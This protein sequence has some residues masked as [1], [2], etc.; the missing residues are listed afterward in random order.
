[1]S[2]TIVFDFDGTLALGN[3][4]VRAF[5][6]AIEDRIGDAGFVARA[7]AAVAG[8]E[9]GDNSFRDGY[10]AVTSIAIADGVH[11]DLLSDAY[12][13]SRTLLGS[14]DAAVVFP[15]GLPNFLEMISTRAHIVLA[16]NAPRGR[17]VEV[18]TSWG[19]EH[20]FDGMHFM[21]GKPEGL[22]PVLRDALSRGRVLSVGDIA[23]FDLAPAL[24][25]GADT[26]LVG[27]TAFYSAAPATMRGHTLTDLYDQISEWVDAASPEL[28]TS[29]ELPH[30]TERNT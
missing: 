19:V 30:P 22:N 21:V 18:L 2:P 10:D 28:R 20:A 12:E 6:R 25:L 14:E 8:F 9:G 26:A 24:A 3:G 13:A 29:F 4:P 27:P 7:S 1:M 16:T 5:A 15:V 11:A 17:I 23:E